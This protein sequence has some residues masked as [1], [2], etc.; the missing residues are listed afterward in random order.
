MLVILLLK[1]VIQRKNK[2]LLHK[3]TL[4]FKHESKSF[5]KNEFVSMS[6]Y[7]LVKN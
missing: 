7:R 3:A 6:G 5:L 1:T 2:S 4:Q